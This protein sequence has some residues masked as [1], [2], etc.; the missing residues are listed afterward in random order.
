MAAFLVRR[1]I[2]V[3]I[4]EQNSITFDRSKQTIIVS[5]ERP[6][7]GLQ[8]RTYRWLWERELTTSRDIRKIQY[9]SCHQRFTNL[10]GRSIPKIIIF[11]FGL[12]VLITL[13]MQWPA[14]FCQNNIVEK[15]ITAILYS[16]VNQ[17]RF[18]FWT[19]D[20][21]KSDYLKEEESM[22][23]SFPLFVQL[24]H[25]TE[26]QPRWETWNVD[27]TWSCNQSAEWSSYQAC[28]DNSV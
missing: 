6:H 20:W 28:F 19:N 8:S 4:E 1:C 21:W 3:D 15:I 24:F 12:F 9:N 13:N 25:P 23:K 22:L 10:P 5:R 7:F 26:Q 16:I 14:I 11:L 2:G 18:L 17:E 27:C